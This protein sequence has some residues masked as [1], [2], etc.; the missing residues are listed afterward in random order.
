VTVVERIAPYGVK[1]GAIPP[2]TKAPGRLGRIVA[3][4]AGALGLTG[5]GAAIKRGRASGLL[6]FGLN[7]FTFT[8]A[9]LGSLI[10]VGGGDSAQG[11]QTLEQV[12]KKYPYVAALIAKVQ[13]GGAITAQEAAALRP[14][15][16]K[17]LAQLST[18]DVKRLEATLSASANM[19]PKLPGPV[20]PGE[21]RMAPP[22][23]TGAKAGGG[24]AKRLTG[25]QVMARLD[26]FGESIT[27]AQISGS[28]SNERQVLVREQK[29]IE[30]Q[31]RTARL[32]V[33][34]RR[35]LKDA[36]LRVIRDVEA[37]DDEIAAEQKAANDR[38]A[39]K[40]KA[41]QAAQAKAAKERLA[42]A[43]RE[44]QANLTAL[45]YYSSNP[46]LT[47]AAAGARAKGKTATASGAG[48]FTIGD[49]FQ[50]AVDQFSTFGSNIAGRN[51]IL[52][53]QDAR[54]DLGGRVVG[55]L[56][57]GMSADQIVVR[58]ADAG[59]RGAP[60][61]RHRQQPAPAHRS[62]SGLC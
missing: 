39:T 46:N 51:G 28:R 42:A 3:G 60:R 44:Y 34:Q 53:P 20:A 2:N 23:S 27:N 50:S 45:G 18:A 4:V 31:L 56:S 13:A 59:R 16:G 7:P 35:Q 33:D 49:L 10:F 48:G 37:I 32:T 62:R 54:G 43:A 5:A 38:Q 61:G 52:S 14:F 30:E 1:P 12:V 26:A 36:L 40:S 58:L 19:G 47:R 24:G 29:F 17:S 9:A 41:R 8:A 21:G 6:R 55:N 11:E 22:T 15:R 25:K 57:T